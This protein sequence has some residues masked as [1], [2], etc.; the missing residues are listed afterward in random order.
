MWNWT[1]TNTLLGLSIEF[2]EVTIYG[3]G[4]YITPL[5]AILIR[6][7]AGDEFTAYVWNDENPWS[8]RDMFYSIFT[9]PVRST[10]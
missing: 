1:T 7:A 9:L 2:S 5:Q 6:Q 4:W 3:E 10:P 8:V